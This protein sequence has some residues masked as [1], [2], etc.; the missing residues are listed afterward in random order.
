M[1]SIRSIGVLILLLLANTTLV[2]A[3]T[4]LPGGS[5]M[6]IFEMI[7]RIADIDSSLRIDHYSITQRKRL[8]NQLYQ[9]DQRYRDSLVNGAKS[10]LKQQLF[11]HRM[12]ANDQANQVLLNK[13]VNR[14]GWPTIKQYGDQEAFTA[15]LIV[16]HSDLNYQR[17]Y[18]PLIKSAYERG[19]IKQ[20]HT[21]LGQR[22]NRYSK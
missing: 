14:F 7:S 8:L 22:L 15:W 1:W 10:A 3:Q 16:W 17:R 5:Q 13:I 20:S 19:L 4:D 2:V 18:Y 6:K 21:E 12:V 11:T 9:A